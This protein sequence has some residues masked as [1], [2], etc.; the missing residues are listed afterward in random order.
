MLESTDIELHRASMN[1]DR[2]AFGVIV[3][4]YQSM[5]CAVAFSALGDKERS[6]DVAQDALIAAWTSLRE[7]R[8]PSKL[9]P[10][11][12]GIARN[13]ALEEKRRGI[14]R[15]VSLGRWGQ[16]MQEVEDPQINAERNQAQELLWDALA[17]IPD[18]YREPL[19]LYYSDGKSI[20][21]VAAALEISEE[22][23]RQRLSRGRNRLKESVRGRVG[24]ALDQCA[25]S[26]GFKGRV[27]AALPPLI[28]IST[29]SSASAATSAGGPGGFASGA[30]AKTIS[31]LLMF[32]G[33][34]V[35]AVFVLRSLAVQVGESP[36]EQYASRNHS[37]QLDSKV[38]RTIPN[39]VSI[40]SS[41]SGKPNKGCKL[42][43]RVVDESGGALVHTEVL[44]RR[45]EEYTTLDTA[46]RVSDERGYF[47]FGE[48]QSSWYRVSVAEPNR[49]PD[50]R[51][52][53]CVDGVDGDVELQVGKGDI[54]VHGRIVD[55]DGTPLAGTEVT[56][57]EP[58]QDKESRAFRVATYAYVDDE[59]NYVLHI[60][61]TDGRP[62]V[63]YARAPG[64]QFTYLDFQP[65]QGE[66]LKHDFVL[67]RDAV[68]E[69]VVLMPDG[70]P[71]VGAELFQGGRWAMLG[72]TSGE[73]GEF[74]MPVRPGRTLTL[75]ARHADLVAWQ[76]QVVVQSTGTK[77]IVL[78]L[79]PGRRVRGVVKGP[80]GAPVV[81]AQVMI[82]AQFT[83]VYVLDTTNHEGEFEVAGLPSDTILRARLMGAAAGETWI[84]DVEQSFVELS[85]DADGRL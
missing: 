9:R 21:A 62:Y 6:E 23:A 35:I 81:G 10:W 31:L 84:R 36:S 53:Q 69:G 17:E 55:R 8:D 29:A 79:R 56:I 14:E 67:K 74:S 25:P 24:S 27:L 22:A 43:G 63:L 80:G 13:R 33:I 78:R 85:L 11:L 30:M 54:R 19:V 44:L 16:P 20:S 26:R 41:A 39:L 77:S 42:S 65:S 32:F 18:T 73:D 51:A 5:M 15:S 12:C 68:V 72:T 83:G 58:G 57:V 45:Q 82:S 64:H 37:R 48:V 71:A 70:T 60:P 28:G 46:T 49:V 61:Y 52:W 4:R 66:E 40:P 50:T 75:S 3:S 1:G 59:G 38:F 7:L 47:D 76:D 2:D 34:A